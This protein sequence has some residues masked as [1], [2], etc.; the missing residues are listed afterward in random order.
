MR[1]DVK[2]GPAERN[3][4]QIVRSGVKAYRV[5]GHLKLGNRAHE[6]RRVRS[7]DIIH[8]EVQLEQQRFLKIKWMLQI[9]GIP[10]STFFFT[11][12]IPSI[13]IM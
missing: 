6:Y 5:Q 4:A 8:F 7:D 12:I 3:R 1:E 11:C 2:L 13:Y 10:F 9:Y